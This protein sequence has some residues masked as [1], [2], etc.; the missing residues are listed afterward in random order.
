MS[1]HSINQRAVDPERL[2]RRLREERE[3]RGLSQT[4]VQKLTGINR[5]NMYRIER[6]KHVPSLDTLCALADAYGMAVSDFLRVESA[7]VQT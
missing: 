5:T 2:C 3:R 1:I 7:D 6:G 4:D